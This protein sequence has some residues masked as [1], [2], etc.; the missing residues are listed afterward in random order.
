MWRHLTNTG[1]LSLNLTLT[2]L[3]LT[4]NVW[5]Q[6]SHGADEG[7]DLDKCVTKFGVQTPKSDLAIAKRNLVSKTPSYSHL[8][9]CLA[10]KHTVED[11]FCGAHFSMRVYQSILQCF[12][13]CMKEDQRAEIWFCVHCG[14]SPTDTYDQVRAVHGRNT[15]YK[16]PCFAGMPSSSLETWIGRTRTTTLAQGNWLKPTW[17]KF[18]QWWMKTTGE[19]SGKWLHKWTFQ[20]VQLTLPCTNLAWEKYWRLEYC[21]CSLQSRSCTGSHVLMLLSNCS[22]DATGL[23]TSSQ[24]MN[25]GFI[26]G[27]QAARCPVHSGSIGKQSHAHRSH[28]LSSQPRNWCWSCS[29][30]NMGLFT[31]SSSLTALG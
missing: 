27:N 12:N 20:K 28:A 29:S 31:V 21:I 14:L 13:M 3:K 24:E 25:L 18:M 6:A 5:D 4:S 15:L 8:L 1:L 11:F 26:V 22:D 16:D 9:S 7:R 30:T 10:R 17:I 23:C 19:L 2:Q